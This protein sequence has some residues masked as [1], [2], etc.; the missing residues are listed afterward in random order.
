MVRD[1]EERDGTDWLA[2]AAGNEALAEE[3]RTGICRCGKELAEESRNCSR[4]QRAGAVVRAALRLAWDGSAA[5]GGPRGEDLELLG[6][7]MP[8][9]LLFAYEVLVHRALVV[10][11]SGRGYDEQVV[12]GAG[13][14]VGGLG[15]V[16]SGQTE[17]SLS[18]G[19]PS[20]RGSSLRPVVRSEPSLAFR[21]KID[22]RLRKLA[23][24]ILQHLEG[25]L[26]VK[27]VHRC[28]G[29]KCG[30]FAEEGWYFC[31][32]CGAAVVEVEKRGPRA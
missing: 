4:H 1:D 11:G 25:D 29:R 23:K 30:Q 21:R 26:S 20:K 8:Q 3:L 10:P 14:S 16:K 28:S 6:R 7:F 19:T 18:A 9:D 17:R 32:S 24:E 5:L 15:G 13:K 22:R 2:A 27:R 12:V 31:P